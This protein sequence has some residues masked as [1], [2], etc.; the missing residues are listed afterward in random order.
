MTTQHRGGRKGRSRSCPLT[1]TGF[2]VISYHDVELLREFIDP[3]SGRII[4]ARKTGVRP[5]LQR[6]LALAIQRARYMALLPMAGPEPN[7]PPHRGKPLE[8]LRQLRARRD[9]AR[10]RARG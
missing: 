9:A 3:A 5:Q 10:A 8:R 4:P 2:T 6:Q 7:A 1:A